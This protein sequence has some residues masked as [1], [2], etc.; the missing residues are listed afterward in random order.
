MGRRLNRVC[1]IKY[2]SRVEGWLDVCGKFFNMIS[3][4]ILSAFYVCVCASKHHKFYVYFG[5][6]VGFFT[7]QFF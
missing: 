2:P 4:Y 6:V 1:E 7:N 3:Q 5:N